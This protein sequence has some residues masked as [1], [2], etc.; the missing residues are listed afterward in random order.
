MEFI[1]NEQ[2]LFKGKKVPLSTCKPIFAIR[3]TRLLHYFTP[4]ISCKNENHQLFWKPV[5]SSLPVDRQAPT[6][7]LIS[8]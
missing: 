8:T 1:A 5:L 4:L 7:G 6:R 2:L 3:A